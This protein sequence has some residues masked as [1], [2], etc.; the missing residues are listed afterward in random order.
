[1][2]NRADEPSRGGE[3]YLI[4]RWQDERLEAFWPQCTGTPDMPGM[5]REEIEMVKQSVCTFASREAVLRAAL[6]AERELET[7]R[8]FEPQLLGRLKRAQESPAHTPEPESE[9]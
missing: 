3:F 9:D 6:L 2:V 4:A 5:K 7:R 1:M 8:M